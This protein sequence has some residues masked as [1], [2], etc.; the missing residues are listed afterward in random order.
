MTSSSIGQISGARPAEPNASKRSIQ[1]LLGLVHGSLQELAR[2]ELMR[3]F[4]HGAPH[5][6]RHGEANVGIDVHL[7][8]AVADSLAYLS[9]RNA[10]GLTD[11]AAVTPDFLQ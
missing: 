11:I 7:A 5:R 1:D 2:I 6:G 3:V 10:V 9:N 8:H 4:L